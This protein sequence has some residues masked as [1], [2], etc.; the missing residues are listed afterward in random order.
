MTHDWISSQLITAR[1]EDAAR[2][3]SRQ[4]RRRPR[5]LIRSPRLRRITL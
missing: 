3:A 1:T 4:E 2:H 5:R